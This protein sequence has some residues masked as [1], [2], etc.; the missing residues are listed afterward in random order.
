MK[1]K[2]EEILSKAL[3]EIAAN[4]EGYVS[5][6]TPKVD[7]SKCSI[8]FIADSREVAESTLHAYADAVKGREFP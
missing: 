4:G 2:S 8:V 1:A 3:A 7:S 6:H 5:M